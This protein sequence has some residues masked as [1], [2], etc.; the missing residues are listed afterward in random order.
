VASG[1]R[2]RGAPRE[3]TVPSAAYSRARGEPTAIKERSIMSECEINRVLVSGRLV[4]DPELREL[5]DGG[6]VCF[7][8]VAC[9]AAR[10]TPGGARDRPAEFDVVAVGATARR[11]ARCLC[12][13]RGV[14]VPGSLESERWEAGEGPEREAV[15]VLAERVCFMGRP[16]RR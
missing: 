8:R 15:C 4:C 5:P 12:R 1:A 11:A 7:L 3:R 14:V 2:A 9:A 10:R 6:P 16:P 13:G